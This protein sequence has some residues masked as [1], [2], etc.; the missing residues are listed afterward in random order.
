MTP[1]DDKYPVVLFLGTF[2]SFFWVHSRAF[3]SP[4]LVTLYTNLH[5]NFATRKIFG[6]GW[7]A[8]AAVC[9][10]SSSCRNDSRQ[11]RACFPQT[12]LAVPSS[13]PES[14]L[15]TFYGGGGIKVSGGKSNFT[16][17]EPSILCCPLGRPPDAIGGKNWSTGPH[18]V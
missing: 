7:Y 16:K 12:I 6:R 18:F 5:E 10:V 17:R 15:S 8:C 11:G 1:S 3:L 9:S 14:F 4:F 13:F 2:Q